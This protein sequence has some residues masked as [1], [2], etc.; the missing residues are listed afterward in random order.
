MMIKPREYSTSGQ[1]VK[2][3]KVTAGQK[4]FAPIGV[5]YTKSSVKGTL[6][7][8]IY[9]IVIN[10]LE[11]DNNEGVIHVEKFW[12][13]ERAL[14][15]I[16]NWSISMRFDAEFDCEDRDSIEKIIAHGQVFIGNVKVTDDGEYTR[17]EIDAFMIAD[18]II[19][20]QG[21]LILTDEMNKYIIQGEEAFPKMIESARNYGTVFINPKEGKA[22]SDTLNGGFKDFSEEDIPF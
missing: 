22:V 7:L 9:C 16:A 6:C 13:S 15:K 5:A 18:N 3:K 11:K 4:V 12:V 1:T 8:N 17:R 14:W 21:N 20:D 19:D 10:D 2:P